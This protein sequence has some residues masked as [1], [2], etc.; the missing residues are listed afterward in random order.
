MSRFCFSSHAHYLIKN[1]GNHRRSHSRCYLCVC[2]GVTGITIVVP[3]PFSPTRRLRSILFVVV[4]AMTN[5]LPTAGSKP[6][7]DTNKW[8]KWGF[9]C[10]ANTLGVRMSSR[11]KGRRR[12][13]PRMALRLVER[14]AAALAMA[15]SR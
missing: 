14:T 12:V 4:M 1:G 5:Q 15:R 8:Q 6:V 11:G 7:A 9:F 2:V 3:S 10:L 13:I